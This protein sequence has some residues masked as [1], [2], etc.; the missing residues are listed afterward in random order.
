MLFGASNVKTKD[1]FVI[2]GVREGGMTRRGQLM[3]AV[4]GEGTM[5]WSPTK[6]VGRGIALC[7][8]WLSFGMCGLDTA[9][10][11]HSLNVLL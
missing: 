8:L 10:R 4:Q 2:H 6:G 3:P 11:T 5:G 9:H 1:Y 7:G